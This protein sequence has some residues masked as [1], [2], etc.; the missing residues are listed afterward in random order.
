MVAIEL[1]IRENRGH[2]EPGAE[3]G[4]TYGQILALFSAVVAVA[5]YIGQ[6]MKIRRETKPGKCKEKQ[7]A[8]Y[9]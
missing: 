6:L 5:V 4:W 7:P 2:V 3:D 9:S 1:T 8:E